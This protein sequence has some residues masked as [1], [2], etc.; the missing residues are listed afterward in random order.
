MSDKKRLY[1]KS[2]RISRDKKLIT[3]CRVLA[4][5]QEIDIELCKEFQKIVGNVIRKT[6]GI[7]NVVGLAMNGEDDV[8]IIIYDIEAT[9]DNYYH[10]HLDEENGVPYIEV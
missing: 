1:P 3:Y 10:Q 6:F 4:K 7:N 9:D 5:H 2:Y 8:L